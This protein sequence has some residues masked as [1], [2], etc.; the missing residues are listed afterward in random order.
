MKTND[1]WA[2]VMLVALWV[3]ILVAG[4]GPAIQINATNRNI[5]ALEQ[6]GAALEQ[7]VEVLDQRTD[8]VLMVDTQQIGLLYVPAGCTVFTSTDGCGPNTMAVGCR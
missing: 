6:T 7:R 3:G 8:H 1:S 5:A 4:V 2:I